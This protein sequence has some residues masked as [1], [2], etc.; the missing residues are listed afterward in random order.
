MTKRLVFL[1]IFSLGLTAGAYAQ[2]TVQEL[3]TQREVLI[4]SGTSTSA[5]DSQ[6]YGLGHVPKAIVNMSGTNQIEFPFYQAIPQ[7]K[8]QRIQSRLMSYYSYVTAIDVLL[9]ENKIRVTYSSAP[10]AEMI[11][12]LVSHFSYIG[13]E[14]H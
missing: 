9:S 6:L 3:L 8:V 11:N 5:I 13:H 12:E 2:S 1:S 10:T 7:E 4:A 14:V